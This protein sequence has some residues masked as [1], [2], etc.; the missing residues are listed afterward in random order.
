MHGWTR[1]SPL[2]LNPVGWQHP[3]TPW[4][5]LNP[6][7][8]GILSPTH[9]EGGWHTLTCLEGHTLPEP[10]GPGSLPGSD[11]P[12]L[13]TVTAWSDLAAAAPE[14]GRWGMAFILSGGGRKSCLGPRATPALCGAPG[15]PASLSQGCPA[16][17]PSHQ[18]SA[19]SLPCPGLFPGHPHFCAQVCV[20]WAPVLHRLCR[21]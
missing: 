5:S 8:G 17:G 9:P 21:P 20:S 15:G 10:S 14:S 6:V 7:P 19:H 12:G 3:L 2:H 13:D 4:C 11:S 18:Q 16:P 1:A